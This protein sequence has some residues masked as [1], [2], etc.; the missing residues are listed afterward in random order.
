LKWL[1]RSVAG[2]THGV[3]RTLGQNAF[4]DC[5]SDENSLPVRDVMRHVWVWRSG[6]P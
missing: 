4:A 3:H 1:A 6:E 2:P 5:V